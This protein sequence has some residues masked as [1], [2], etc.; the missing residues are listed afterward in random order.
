MLN[1]LKFK[2]MAFTEQ[3]QQQQ[4]QKQQHYHHHIP[5]AQLCIA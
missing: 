4:Q 2:Y 5:T 3:Q 1:L